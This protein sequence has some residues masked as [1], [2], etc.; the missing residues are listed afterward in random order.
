MSNF[1]RQNE[2]NEANELLKVQQPH[3][4]SSSEMDK[5]R[6]ITNTAHSSVTI[7]MVHRD[8]D[9]FFFSRI[10]SDGEFQLTEPWSAKIHDKVVEQVQQCSIILHTYES[11]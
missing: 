11:V 8:G 9:K 7:T 3:L 5:L 1:I 6:C 2:V 10:L 4:E